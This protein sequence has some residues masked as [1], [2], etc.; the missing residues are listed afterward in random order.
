MS[1]LLFLNENLTIEEATKLHE[2]SEALKRIFFFKQV[3]AAKS[4]PAERKAERLAFCLSF[5]F[6]F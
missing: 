2:E 1:A 5:I 4:L 6:S 3:A